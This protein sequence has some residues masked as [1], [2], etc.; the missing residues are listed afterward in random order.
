MQGVPNTQKSVT[1]DNKNQNMPILPGF[2]RDTFFILGVTFCHQ[3]IFKGDTLDFK[4]FVNI[5]PIV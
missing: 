5:R 3:M 4:D 2:E 1:F